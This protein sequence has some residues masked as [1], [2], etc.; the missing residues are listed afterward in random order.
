M[1]SFLTFSLNLRVIEMTTEESRDL[2]LLLKPSHE[3]FWFNNCVSITY[4]LV[5]QYI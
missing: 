4:Q 3:T 5:V 1:V 2:V